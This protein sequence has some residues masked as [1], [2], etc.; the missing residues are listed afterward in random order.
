VLHIFT[1][2]WTEEA[3]EFVI[4]NK[5]PEPDPEDPSKLVYTEDPVI[6]HTRPGRI[7][8][9]VEDEDE[10]EEHGV[11]LFW[12]PPLKGGEDVILIKFNSYSLVLMSFMEK[13]R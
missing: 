2:V 9:W 4:R 3:P 5:E 11:R 6:L 12:Q 1:F 7:I 10:D 8:K 13:R